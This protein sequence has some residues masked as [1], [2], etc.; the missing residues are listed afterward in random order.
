MGNRAPGHGGIPA[1]RCQRCAQPPRACLCPQIP[2]VELDLDVV[3]LRHW[4]EVG[5]G[6]NSG[7]FGPLAV[8]RCEVRDWG[9]R[10]RP[11]PLDD[12]ARPGTWLL[13]PDAQ[14]TD[15]GGLVGPSAVSGL[16]EPRPERVVILDGSWK[17]ARKMVRR[18]GPLAELPRFGL[19]PR[20][21]DV[22]RLRRPPF[23]G[24]MSTLE[25]LA[26]LVEEVHDPERA[27]PLF[28]LYDALVATQRR[29]Q[30][31]R[32]RSGPRGSG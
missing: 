16:P 24:G 26:R 11:C 32:T 27:A 31:L 17:Q 19:S 30:G 21:G 20:T 7:R 6:S 13:F 23:P 15:G 22:D 1:D 12:L 10:D 18:I 2:R 14:P 28:V 25:A 8:P 29:L 5:R 9:E 4:K 3:I